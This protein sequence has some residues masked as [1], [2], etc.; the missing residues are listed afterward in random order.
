MSS[1]HAMNIAEIRIILS[2]IVFACCR[3]SGDWKEA[4]LLN[5]EKS[6]RQQHAADVVSAISCKPSIREVNCVWRLPMHVPARLMSNETQLISRA[7]F[8]T[9]KSYDA[10]G[11]HHYQAVMSFIQA[12]PEYDYYIFDDS[13]ALSFMRRFYPDH[14]HI[15]QQILPGAMKADIWRLAVI[16][17]YG[18]VY[19]DSDSHSV[20]PLREVIWP[21]ASVVT[22]IGASN[23]FHQWALLYTPRHVLIKAALKVALQRTKALYHSRVA[24]HVSKTTGP[25]AFH[26]A[27]SE[28]LSFAK[29]ALPVDFRTRYKENEIIPFLPLYY[30]G[31]DIGVMQIY[32]GD[33]LGGNVI[34]KD[35]NVEREKNLVSVY[36]KSAEKRYETLFK[37]SDIAKVVDRTVAKSHSRAKFKEPHHN[38]Q[39][40]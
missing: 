15:Y 31:P 13:A 23:D 3:A 25:A 38:T 20:T 10:A 6:A 27:V 29:C 40:K 14:V 39:Q 35:L 36:Y 4:W 21:N 34:F 24:G 16:Y 32:N 37:T 26:S 9:W 28:V 5:F 17:K 1:C 12:N 8:Q 22:G 7:I 2:L 19:L 30:C 18:G 33:F 11:F